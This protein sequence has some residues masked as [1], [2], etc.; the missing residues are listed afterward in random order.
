M[1]SFASLY[2]Q[3]STV[4]VCCVR[5]WPRNEEF[6]AYNPVWRK[7]MI[8]HILFDNT[9]TSDSRESMFCRV[10]NFRF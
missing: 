3:L 8:F 5:A 4:F 7:R 1:T 2:K 10:L 9:Q 6:N